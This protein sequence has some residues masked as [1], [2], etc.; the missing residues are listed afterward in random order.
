MTHTTL[1]QDALD[2]GFQR[3]MLIET[4][5]DTGIVNAL[6]V[7]EDDYPDFQSVVHWITVFVNPK[8]VWRDCARKRPPIQTNPTCTCYC[9]CGYQYYQ[10][11]RMQRLAEI[12]SKHKSLVILPSFL[13]KTFL[14]KIRKSTLTLSE[15]VLFVISQ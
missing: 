2:Y 13:P 3:R 1:H 9:V 4:L 12:Q 8:E 11:K 10:E 14:L 6:Y 7:H 5:W 15:H